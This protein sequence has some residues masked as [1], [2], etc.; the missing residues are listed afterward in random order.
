MAHGPKPTRTRPSM[1]SSAAAQHP[2][3]RADMGATHVRRVCV[4]ELSWTSAR[5]V[6]CSWARLAGFSPLR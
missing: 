6:A 5:G 4:V 2:R 3:A 1:S